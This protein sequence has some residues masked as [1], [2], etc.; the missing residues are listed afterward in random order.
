[1]KLSLRTRGFKL[2][3]VMI[4]MSVISAVGLV[5]YSLLNINTVLGAKNTAVNTAHQQ[6]RIA[7]LQMVQDL[8]SAVSLPQLVNTDGITPWPSPSP[9]AS[10]SPA[11]GIAFQQ[12][13]SVMVNGALTSNGG[14]HK[15]ADDVD[16][17][18]DEIEIVLT[19]GQAVPQVGQRLI[20]PTH[21]IEDTIIDVDPDGTAG[22]Y[23]IRLANDIGDLDQNGALSA[24]EV[25]KDRSIRGTGSD[26]GDVVCFI[27]DR[28]SY[29]VVN[30][31]T[32]ANPN[33]VLRWKKPNTSSTFSVMGTDITNPTPFGTP[34][35]PAG[36]LYHRF[37]AAIDLSTADSDYK[38][39]GF[40]A[41][42]VLLNGQ[43]PMR[44][45][46]TTYQ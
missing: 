3:E 12:W 8:R 20:V 34:T 29:T 19:P 31:A 38:N 46:L 28:C 32:T 39:R 6:A 30:T 14:P 2:V 21:Q 26:I 15:I 36:A 18:D 37:V 9:G 44:A 40:K 5:I 11:P 24:F 10:P 27:T 43:I 35:T 4:S 41:A 33:Y 16:A 7:M 17:D 25:T 13:G 22:K 42:N 1:M 23:D 45:R